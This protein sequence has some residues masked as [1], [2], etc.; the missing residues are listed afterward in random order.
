MSWLGCSGF[1]T[2]VP[3][4]GSLDRRFCN[5]YSKRNTP[6]QLDRRVLRFNAG[7]FDYNASSYI[8]QLDS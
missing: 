2:V 1:P 7:T 6:Y 3:F 8:R 5:Y 4:L